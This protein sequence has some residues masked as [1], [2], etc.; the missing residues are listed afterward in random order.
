MKLDLFMKFGSV[1]GDLLFLIEFVVEPQTSQKQ[2]LLIIYVFNSRF[3]TDQRFRQKKNPLQR[4]RTHHPA[5]P[6]GP[7]AAIKHL[8]SAEKRSIRRSDRRRR[9]H[10]PNRRSDSADPGPGPDPLPV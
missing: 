4:A 10:G 2:I 9:R 3:I 7:P 1:V 6:R 8:G 5:E